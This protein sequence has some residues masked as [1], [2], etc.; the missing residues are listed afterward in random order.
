MTSFSNRLVFYGKICT[1]GGI[2][3]EK[4]QVVCCGHPQNIYCMLNSNKICHCDR[5]P[6]KILNGI[7]LILDDQGNHL[8]SYTIRFESFRSF[9]GLQFRKPVIGHRPGTL[10][11]SQNNLK[12]P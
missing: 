4:T 11:L 5:G 6:L 8:D 9:R 2:E 10:F 12:G 3:V 1:T 7:K